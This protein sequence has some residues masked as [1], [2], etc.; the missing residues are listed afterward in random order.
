[1]G[2][3]Q[4][5]MEYPEIFRKYF[6][7]VVPHE[8]NKFSALNG[9]VWSG[10]SFVYV[11]KGVEVPLPLQAYFRINGENTG[12]FERT[13]IVVDEGAKVHYI[14]GCC[15]SPSSSA[16]ATTWFRSTDV[17]AGMKVDEQ[18]R[19]RGAGRPPYDAGP[20]SGDMLKIVPVSVGN[21][22]EV[23]PEHPVL[24]SASRE[25]AA[26]LDRHDRGRWTRQPSTRQ[27]PSGS[28]QASSRRGDLIC[29]P[30]AA[31]EQDHP[32]TLG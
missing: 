26:R 25:R 30:V 13:L 27:S 7:T 20:T 29:F 28:R 1:M 15:A 23:T 2:T 9:A 16:S 22:F 12:Q 17:T 19:R 3:D 32:E 8:D 24:A 10:G 6:G 18:R 14:E 5:L 4:G 11:P 21:A 31:K